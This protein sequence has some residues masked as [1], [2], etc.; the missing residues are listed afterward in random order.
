MR[1]WR[2]GPS[3]GR[4]G[5]TKG[6]F[7]HESQI[8]DKNINIFVKE[9]NILYLKNKIYTTIIIFFLTFKDFH[10][11][12]DIYGSYAVCRNRLGLKRQIDIILV[13]A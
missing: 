1:P 9:E 7:F 8:F 6:C 4:F 5:D 12:L 13:F 10:F 11:I 3:P 2:L